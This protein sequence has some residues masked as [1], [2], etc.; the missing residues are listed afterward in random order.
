MEKRKPIDLLNDRE[1][2][3]LA[4]WLTTHPG[5]SVITRDRAGAYA[6]GASRGAP[7]AVQVADRWHLLKNLTEAVERALQSRFTALSSA[8]EVIRQTQISS[9]GAV[10]EAGPTTMLSSRGAE[11]I[12]R[13]RERKLARYGEVMKLQKQ[14][15]SVLGIAQTLKIRG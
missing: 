13:S 11:T 12:T 1:A 2:D 4:E 5:V 6:E 8:A 14:G 7:Q 9:S 15:A 3:T 10:I